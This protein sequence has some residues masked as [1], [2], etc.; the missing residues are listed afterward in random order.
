MRN[1]ALPRDRL[2]V[3]PDQAIDEA[4]AAAGTQHPRHHFEPLA[5]LG[6]AEKVERQAYG[7]QGARL[8]SVRCP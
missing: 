7:D 5:D 4:E 3:G 1:V 8:F 6:R 2:I